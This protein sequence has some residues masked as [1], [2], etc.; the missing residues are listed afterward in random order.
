MAELEK[1]IKEMKE[2]YGDSVIVKKEFAVK[3]YLSKYQHR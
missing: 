2:K 1:F 3:K